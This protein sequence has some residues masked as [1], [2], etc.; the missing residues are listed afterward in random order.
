MGF[1]NQHNDVVTVVQ[2]IGVAI[3]NFD[4]FKFKDGGDQN[5]TAV[6]LNVFAKL[7]TTLHFNQVF[8]VGPT[9]G[10]VNLAA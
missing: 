7:F 10:L 1:V 9:K 6:L 4:I 3:I 5:A 8:N 2:A